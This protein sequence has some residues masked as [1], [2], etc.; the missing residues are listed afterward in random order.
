MNQS[1]G[2][3]G[4]IGKLLATVVT[5]SEVIN[6]SVGVVEKFVDTADVYAEDFKTTA[7]AELELKQKKRAIEMEKLVA[8][9]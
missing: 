6:K 5:A 2:I 3:F 4:A 8:D 9:V 1:I 7:M